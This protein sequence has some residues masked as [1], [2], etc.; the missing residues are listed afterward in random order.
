MRD[1]KTMHDVP[2]G[3]NLDLILRGTI[4]ALNRFTDVLGGGLQAIALAL[5]TPQDNSGEVQKKLDEVTKN[6]KSSTD[7]LQQAIDSAPQ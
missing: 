3:S 6:M 5:S 2:R 4:G 1:D 7:A